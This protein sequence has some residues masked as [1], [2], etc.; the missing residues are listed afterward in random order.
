MV[1]LDP[2]EAG[3][4]YE[5]VENYKMRDMMYWIWCLSISLVSSDG[6]NTVIKVI[7]KCLFQFKLTNF[8]NVLFGDVW[9][10]SGQS[11]MEMTVSDVFNATAEIADANNYPNIR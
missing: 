7:T 3:G 8:Q 10:C 4:P 9:I 11:N 5:Y 1:T 2:T 6:N